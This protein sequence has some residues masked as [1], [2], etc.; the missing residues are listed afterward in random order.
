MTIEK[1]NAYNSIADFYN[2]NIIELIT[3][4][5]SNGLAFNKKGTITNNK[6]YTMLKSL[7]N[8]HNIT[9]KVNFS[10]NKNE[11]NL[12]FQKQYIDND[13]ICFYNINYNLNILDDVKNQKELPL[14]LEKINLKSY[15]NHKKEFSENCKQIQKLKSEIESLQ[16]TNKLIVNLYYSYKGFISFMQKTI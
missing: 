11:L 15:L 14:N 3:F 13:K 8:P 16:E 7:K 9:I 6:F 2:Q 5:K 4:I 10:K 1:I 12:F